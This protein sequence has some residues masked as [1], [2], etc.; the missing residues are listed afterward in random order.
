MVELIL[1]KAL[2]GKDCSNKTDTVYSLTALN[3]LSL[4]Q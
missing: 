1:I 3:N 4:T 2:R